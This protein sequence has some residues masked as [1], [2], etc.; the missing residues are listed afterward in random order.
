MYEDLKAKHDKDK[1]FYEDALETRTDQLEQAESK[2]EDSK[3]QNLNLRKQLDE[4]NNK[5]EDLEV[6]LDIQN[7][8]FKKKNTS[9]E[10][11]KSDHFKSQLSRLEEESA[12][13]RQELESMNE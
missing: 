4:A 10:K 6:E 12:Q 2:L 7:Q 8:E 13:L 9:G 3:R 1:K 11:T 5:V